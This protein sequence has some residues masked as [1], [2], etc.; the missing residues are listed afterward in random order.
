[1]SDSLFAMVRFCGGAQPG[2]GLNICQQIAERLSG[3]ILVNSK[4]MRGTTMIFTFKSPMD[5]QKY[6]CEPSKK[7]I[8]E[9]AN[10]FKTQRKK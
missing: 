9:K 1:M 6:G 7:L 4:Y 8:R 10:R 2:L 3:K 5:D